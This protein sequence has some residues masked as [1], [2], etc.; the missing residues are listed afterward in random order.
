VSRNPSQAALLL[1]MGEV[2]LPGAYAALQRILGLLAQLARWRGVDPGA[3]APLPPQTVSAP[4]SLTPL[5]LRDLAQ[6]IH[7]QTSVMR[8]LVRSSSRCAAGMPIEN[9]QAGNSPGFE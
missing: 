8:S 3:Q 9:G 7:R 6:S 4:T 1:E 5:D 2:R